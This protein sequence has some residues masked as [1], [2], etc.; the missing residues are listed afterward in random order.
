MNYDSAFRL[1]GKVAL[2][3]GGARGLGAEIVRAFAQSGAS[4]LLTDILTKEGSET[5]ETVKSAGGKASF[6]RHDVRNEE[7]WEDAVATAIR[8]FGGLD[9]LVNNAGI[10]RMQFVTECAVDDFREI[11]DVNVTGTFLGC[12]HAIRVMRPDGKVG[13]GGAIINLSSVAGNVGIAGL[14]AYNASKGAVRLLT[15][16][17]AMECGQLKLNVRCNSIHPAVVRTDMAKSF[18]QHF[19]DLKLMSDFG[20]AEATLLSNHPIGKFGEP[21]DVACAALYLASDASKW[22]TGSELMV[23]GGFTAM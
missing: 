18:F 6:L 2:V 13:K 19:V 7:Q 17:V 22:V 12:K 3:T 10:E 8:I 14:G 16:S 5:V 21:S 23:D 20:T 1:D 4:V 11:L 9:I 15:K